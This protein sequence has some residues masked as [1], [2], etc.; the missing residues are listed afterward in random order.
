MYGKRKI[1]SK[2]SRKLK[3]SEGMACY[4]ILIVPIVGFLVFI[5]YPYLWAA[6]WSFFNYTGVASKTRFVG[7]QNFIDIFTKDRSYWNAW[8]V[9]LKFTL[10]KLPIEIPLALILATILQRDSLRCKGIFRSIYY[11]PSIVSVAIVGAIF[12]NLYDYRGVINS[13]LVKFN[14]IQ[15]PVDWFA[16]YTT[17]MTVL[18][19]ASIWLSFGVNVLYFMAALSNVPAELYEAASV[20]GAGRARKFFS[21]TLPSIAPVFQTILLLAINGTLQTG[22]FII[23]LSNGAP[24]G[25]TFTVGAYL[26][27]SFVPGFATGRPNIGYGSALSLITSVFYCLIAVVYMKASAR[28]ADNN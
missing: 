9:T 24:S 25:T 18:L 28:F 20:E 12:S 17:S 21:I 10:L 1:L 23:V 5:L 13:W 27:N 22:E 26:I 19:T 15:R 2:R 14:I 6:K 11:L 16:N 7:W 4:F 8:L 3:C